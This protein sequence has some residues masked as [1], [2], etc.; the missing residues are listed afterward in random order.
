ME[1]QKT[2]ELDSIDAYN[3]KIEN[4]TLFGNLDSQLSLF[5]LPEKLSQQNKEI[6]FKTKE[7]LKN[8]IKKS[9]NFSVLNFKGIEFWCF[10]DLVPIPTKIDLRKLNKKLTYGNILYNKEYS[11]SDFEKDYPNSFKNSPKMATSFFQ[12]V[13]KETS[14]NL[15]HY[16]VERSNK[17]DPNVKP[18]VEFTF[19]NDR[20]IFIFFA[21]F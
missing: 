10:D 14:K 17:S 13:T 15:K 1:G 5:G 11:L 12:M 7:H 9:N 18:L 16:F 2:S 3:I 21:N 20:L 8:Q 19:E 4:V 6:E